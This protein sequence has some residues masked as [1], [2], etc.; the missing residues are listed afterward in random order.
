MYKGFDVVKKLF[1]V[2]TAGSKEETKAAKLIQKECSSLGVESEIEKFKIDSYSIKEAGI[3]FFSPSIEVEC[4]GVGMSGSTD[5]KGIRRELVYVDSLAACDVLDLENKI[6]LIHHKFANYKM[7]KRL[8]EKKAAGII[9]CAGDVYDAHDDIDIDP[10]MYRE[11]HYSLGKIPA[12]CIKLKDADAIVKK[13]PKE[14]WIKVV[15]DEKKIDSRNVIATIEGTKYKDEIIA[16]TAHYDSVP[17]SKGAFDN[18]TGVA[19]ILQMM[20]HY[21]NNPPLRTLKFIFCGAEEIGLEGSKAYASMHE[22][23]LK[24]YK[25]CINV[26]MIAATLGLDEAKCTSNTSLV[27]YIKY[28]S[29]EVGFPITA[30]QMIYSSDSSSFA[31]KGVPAV[32]FVRNSVGGGAEIH[33]KKDIMDYLDAGSFYRTCD[34]M[35]LVCDRLINSCAFPVEREIPSNMK[36]ELDKYFGRKEA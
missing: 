30:R 11:R 23:S 14:V 10:Y 7:Y 33:S 25:L 18:A 5:E 1:F 28:L 36:E 13:M 21:K 29:A 32:S 6:C 16:F 34:F 9:M 2:R 24:D 27:S 8:I 31:D 17:F 26:D 15:Q 3:K 20:E 4:V 12:V 35:K 19:A 22:E